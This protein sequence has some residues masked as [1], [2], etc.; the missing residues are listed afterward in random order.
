M[1][2]SIKYLLTLLLIIFIQQKLSAQQ[3]ITITVIENE[4]IRKIANKYLNDSNLWEDILRVNNL[5]SPADVKPGTKLIIPVVL[6]K[7]NQESLNNA[8]IA[9][10]E[11]SKAGAK[12]FA[13]NLISKAGNLYEDA[14][15][16]KKRR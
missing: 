3:S 15:K 12:L 1:K 16:K 13:V 10:N 9:I 2:D 8:F 14:I 11:A 5:L 7:E 4:T 6:I